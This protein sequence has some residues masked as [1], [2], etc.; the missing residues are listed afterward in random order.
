MTLIMLLD[1]IAKEYTQSMKGRQIYCT[2]KTKLDQ[3]HQQQH[4]F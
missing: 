4:Y 1:D 2:N 3:T